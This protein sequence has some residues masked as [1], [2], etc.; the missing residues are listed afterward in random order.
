MGAL[1]RS[2]EKSRKTRRESNKDQRGGWKWVF[3]TWRGD[4]TLDRH[5]ARGAVERNKE[6]SPPKIKFTSNGS[7]G[8]ET[9]H[10]S[11][12]SLSALMLSSNKLPKYISLLPGANVLKRF[13]PNT[14]GCNL[15][16]DPIQLKYDKATS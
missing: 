5:G 1:L 15:L 2:H 3:T 4:E 16:L 9:F 11:F 7:F 8:K 6:A 12:A 10:G 14:N 13:V